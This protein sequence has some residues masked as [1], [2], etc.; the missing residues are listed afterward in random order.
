MTQRWHTF[1]LLSEGLSVRY[2]TLA[3]ACSIDAERC[4]LV[5]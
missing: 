4:P 5:G 3:V 1:C 2:R